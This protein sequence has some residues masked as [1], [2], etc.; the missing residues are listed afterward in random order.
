[1]LHWLANVQLKELMQTMANLSELRKKKR[2]NFLNCYK[3]MI[4][5]IGGFEMQKYLLKH[6]FFSTKKKKYFNNNL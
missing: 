1:M 2:G 6:M 5:F 4:S 3:K